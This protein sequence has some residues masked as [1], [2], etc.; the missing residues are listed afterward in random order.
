MN[1]A[2]KLLK[3][4][5]TFMGLG[6]TLTTNEIKDIINAI[7]FLEH[8]A[9]LLK[10]NTR[11]INSQEGDFLQ[12]LMTAGLPLVKNVLTP[13]AR[14]VLL[15]LGLIAAASATDAAIPVKLFEWQWVYH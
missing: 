7:K 13:L 15:P 1:S 3:T 6:I 9:I 2:N 12:P 11:K 10:E 5:E 14:S 8:R 4:V